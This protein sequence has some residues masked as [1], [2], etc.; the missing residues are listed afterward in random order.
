MKKCSVMWFIYPR[1]DTGKTNPPYL[2]T[3]T[4]AEVNRNILWCV[5]FVWTV[6]GGT[7]T[8]DSVWFQTDTNMP[9][10]VG[11]HGNRNQTTHRKTEF[12]KSKRIVGLKTDFAGQVQHTGLRLVAEHRDNKSIKSEWLPRNHSHQNLDMENQVLSGLDGKNKCR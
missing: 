2:L 7:W 10:R 4:S 3:D 9:C 6:R 12:T 8:W 1:A 5:C 11:R